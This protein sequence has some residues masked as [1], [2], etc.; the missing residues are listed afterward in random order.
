MEKYTLVMMVVNYTNHSSR[1]YRILCTHY[2]LPYYQVF[3]Y[4]HMILL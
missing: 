2:T 3:G 4:Y 1:I